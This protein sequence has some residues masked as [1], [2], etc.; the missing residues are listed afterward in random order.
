VENLSALEQSL[1]ALNKDAN[2]WK[3]R[4]VI[5][6]ILRAESATAAL[7]HSRK[8]RVDIN[9]G[10]KTDVPFDI[11]DASLA[12]QVGYQTADTSVDLLAQSPIVAFQ[13]SRMREKGFRHSWSGSVMFL[14]TGA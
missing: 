5:T 13:V 6:A 11:A 8:Q 3:N 4:V 9:A 14:D 12:L 1:L 2:W 10:V 7:S